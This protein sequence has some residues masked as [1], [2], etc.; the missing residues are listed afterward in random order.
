MI[1]PVIKELSQLTKNKI[2]VEKI[3]VDQNPVS[4]D[5]YKITD[6]P[7]FVI[8]NEGKEVSRRIGAQSK[9]QLL[10]MFKEAGILA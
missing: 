3:N 2:S 10:D 5:S 1:E 6:V 9:Q 8:F 4:A 7:T